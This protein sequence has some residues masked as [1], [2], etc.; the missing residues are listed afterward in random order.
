[1]DAM[2]KFTTGAVCALGL[3][4]H[5]SLCLAESP[6]VR[7]ESATSGGYG[8]QSLRNGLVGESYPTGRLETTSQETNRSESDATGEVVYSYPV[9][10]PTAAPA[11]KKPAPKPW[12]GLFFNNDFSYLC[13]PEHDHLLGE[14][15]KDISL[16]DEQWFSY[17]GEIRFRFMN[18]DNRIRPGFPKQNNYQLWR[19]RQYLDYHHSDLFRVYFEWMDSAS[20]NEDLPPLNIDEDRWHIQ[21]A[22]FDVFLTELGD[23]QPLYFR[24][25]RQEL[26]YGAERLVSPLDWGNTRRTFEG[27]KLF[28]HGPEWD[29]DAFATRPV[30]RLD[31]QRD[32]GDASLTF[33]GVYATYHG[34]EN[35]LFDFY[36]LWNREQNEVL[37]R[38]DGSRHTTGMRWYYERPVKNVCDEVCGIWAAEV[39]GAYQFGHDNDLTVQAGFFTAGV[40]HTWK[41]L[42]WTPSLW[43]YFDWAS[44]DRDPLDGENNTFNQLYP[45]GHKYLGWFDALARQ[46]IIDY[47][48]RLTVKPAKKLTLNAWMHWF[49]LDSADDALYNAA[50]VPF[51]TNPSGRES[52]DVGEEL[53]LTAK[54]VINPNA[55]VLLGYSWFWNGDFL[56]GLGLGDTG[57]T[58]YVQ[59]TLRY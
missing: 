34:D 11:P 35:H 1:M 53:D 3:V 57:R 26:L 9:E 51:A 15:L 21:N 43:G 27:F 7:S 24:F 58:L 33:S 49:E 42:P 40:G 31:P 6:I 32:R 45:L 44:G 8:E 20:F 54:Y 28:S 56:D 48:M 14:E 10:G 4:F 2:Q 25:G 18:E 38:A 22:F 59:T 37:A 55:D 52:V 30:T 47:N 5:T 39:E 13:D 36:W 29:V 12:K 17:G 46:N 23:S 19:W 16:G 50:G 41:D